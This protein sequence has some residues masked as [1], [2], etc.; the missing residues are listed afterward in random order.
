MT[1]LSGIRVVEMGLWLAG[2]AAGGMLT[3]WGAE[4]IKIEALDGD[5]MRRL[6]GTLS[7]SKESRCPPFDMHNRG[8]RSVA[9]DINSDRGRELAGQLVGT[10][11]VFLTNMR[12]EFLKRVGLDHAT[13]LRA[14]PR[15]VYASLSG[16]GLTGPDRNAPGFDVAAFSARSGV[17]NRSAPEGQPPPTLAG[18][19][20][21]N[22]TAITT[23]AA[24]LA[25]LL[26][27][28]RTGQGQLVSTSLLRTGIYCI[29]MDVATR[30][31]LG[32][33]A[34]PASRTKPQNPLL[35]SY[36][37]GDGKWFWLMGAEAERH[38]PGFVEAIGSPEELN[39]ERFQTPRDR[40][41]NGTELVA[42]LDAIFATKS[43]DE[44]AE[45][46]AEHEVW[47]APVN[48]VEDLLVDPQVLASGAFVDIPGSEDDGPPLKSV[49]TPVEF[50][51]T[52]VGPAGPAPA[53]GQDTDAVLAGLGVDP[54]EIVRLRDEGVLGGEA[55]VE[56]GPQS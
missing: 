24:I 30:L 34:Q 56:L 16:Y 46:F 5:P 21:D 26:Y 22:V 29:G 2:P 31:G 1:L 39:D 54:E 33:L 48:S 12:P 20:G 10:A 9:L 28:E 50:A 52:P 4:V 27:R 17:V 44:W 43:R 51:G 7:G 38:W 25:G 14:N 3:D 36:A 45:K 18:G 40:R 41:R 49:A 32:R 13:L 37:A 35:N 15:L 55:P 6:F 11:D 47:W 53:I 19:L 23:V 42:L 8:K